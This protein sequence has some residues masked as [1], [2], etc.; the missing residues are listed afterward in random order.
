MIAR[1][2]GPQAN[3][4]Q[5]VSQPTEISVISVVLSHVEEFC[6]TWNLPDPTD[7]F[8]KI[9]I[10]WTETKRRAKKKR[11]RERARE[12]ER[13]RV[14]ERERERERETEQLRRGIPSCLPGLYASMA[15]ADVTSGK[16]YNSKG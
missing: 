1:Y 12:R 8:C 14:R 5:Y 13:E 4:D 10:F 2:G 15:G 16:D 6:L 9:C 11:K 3:Y 7:N